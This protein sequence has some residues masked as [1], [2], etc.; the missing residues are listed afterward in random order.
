MRVNKVKIASMFLQTVLLFLSIMYLPPWINT[1]NWDTIITLCKYGTIIGILLFVN[2]CIVQKRIYTPYNLFYLTFFVFQFGLPIAYAIFPKFA[3]YYFNLF[4]NQVRINGLIYS[5][6]CIQVFVYA[7]TPLVDRITQKKQL[8]LT[9]KEK[10]WKED[11]I[12]E[13]ALIMYILMGL[14]AFPLMCYAVLQTLKLGFMNAGTRSFLSS[15]AFFRLIQTFFV[16]S[17]M[18]YL[19]FEKRKLNRN[20]IL[21]TTM[22]YAVLQLICADRAGGLVGL[23]VLAY[24][25]VFVENKINDSKTKQNDLKLEMLFTGVLFVLVILLVY[26]A[27]ARLSTEKISLIDVLTNGLIVN[28][29]SEM[30]FNFTSICFVLKYIPTSAG[31]FHGQSYWI[32]LLSIIPKSLDSTG[33][34]EG[35]YEMLGERWLFNMNN[36]QYQ[37]GLNFGVGFSLIAE[38]YYNFGWCGILVFIVLGIGLAY[39]LGKRQASCSRFET[40]IYMVLMLEVLML[41]RRQ[42]YNLIKSLEYSIIFILIYICVYVWVIYKQKNE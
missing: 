21:L 3:N 1:E 37:G 14:V 12:A 19:C 22:M 2:L 35:M 27:E 34:L 41:P 17:G 39:L 26:V 29:I 5:I 24:Y 36:T 4:T 20:I 23:L 28:L 25:K 6:F 8:E 16:P 18:L 31:I 11:K 13:A 32:A 42:M 30:G 7:S 33:T 10:L 40:Y 15:N 9:T 38:S